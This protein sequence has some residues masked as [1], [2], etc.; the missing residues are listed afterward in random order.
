MAGVVGF[1]QTFVVGSRFYLQRED[2]ANKAVL[3]MG[4]I[5]T[6]QKQGEVTEITL[7]DGDGGVLVEIDSAITAFTETYEITTAN[8]NL[9]NMAL[10][11]LATA[12]EAFTQASGAIAMVEHK[13]VKGPGRYIKI[14][15]TAGEWLYGITSALVKND[16]AS[17]TY[18]ENTDYKWVSKDRGI[19]QILPG[20]A[21]A[22]GDIL[23]ITTTLNA[24]SGKRLI[25]PLTKPVIKGKAMLVYS[26]GGNAQQWVREFN[27]TLKPTST[28]ISITEFS[29]MTFEARAITNPTDTAS[30]A[31]RF[32][33]TV[34]ALPA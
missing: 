25:K 16:G 9:D 5:D 29:K 8:F 26:M 7:Q 6:A 1:Q 21:I 12:P 15:G 10:L 11:L 20:S 22:E 30:P 3:D 33:Q 18:V 24:I 32:I 27:L 13:A 23:E 14:V 4:T 28:N 34:G 17:T 31:G 19:L 2:D